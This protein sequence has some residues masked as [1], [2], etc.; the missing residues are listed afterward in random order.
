MIDD[1]RMYIDGAWSAA[2]SG[3]YLDSVD[4]YRGQV[5]ARVP[6]GDRADVDRAVSAAAR[7]FEQT[8][9]PS[10]AKERA[11]LLHRLADLVEADAEHLAQ[12]ESRDNGKTI[13]EERGATASAAGWYR[14]AA[15]TAETVSGDLPHG[16]DPD[17]LA[18]TVREP[19]G[20]I[21]IQTPWN[22]PSVLLAQ[23]LS[24]ALAAGNTVVVKPSELAPCSTLEFARLVE[25]AG[26]PPG[27]VNVVT[28]MGEVVGEALCRHP[29]VAKLALT[30]GPDAGR[31]V[32]HHAAE[33]LVPAMMELG[34]KSAN[35]VFADA[36]IGATAEALV[37][38]FVGAG[39]QSCVA[40]SRVLAHRSVYD[41]LVGQMS[42]YVAKVRLGDPQDPTTDM[43]PM[44][45]RE[46]VERV[47]RLVAAGQAEGARLIAGGRV[48]ADL[49]GGLFFA[50][51]IFADVTPDMTIAQE[52]I[53]GPVTCV[54][55]FNTEAEAI[56]VNNGTAY[57]LAA[58]IWTNDLDRAHR[59][60]RQLR[61]GTVW[62]NH[63]RRGDAAFPFGGYGQSGYGRVNGI[64]GYRE[65][66]RVKSIQLLLRP[67]S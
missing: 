62:I 31:R 36:D 4:P 23:V 6:R 50:P 13:R 61:A 52:E 54:I 15:A 41:E 59:V 60:A 25:Q 11:R 51:T 5:W 24:M 8:T 55:P 1:Y 66:S 46:Q 29:L 22:T 38:A 45:T 56:T 17:V 57:G 18:L 35:L 3:E 48:P 7:A 32:A 14:F 42:I 19:Y 63:Y 58:G 47:E 65:M 28:G 40:G 33:R 2:A 10:R 37:T 27:V 53:F 12:V 43:G 26:F 20:V 67:V 64:D 44:C 49:S 34:G 30:G 39:G 21:G 16:N 9:W